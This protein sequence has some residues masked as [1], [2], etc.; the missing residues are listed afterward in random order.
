[1]AARRPH[2]QVTQGH[3]V[4]LI[5]A[6][7]LKIRTLKYRQVTIFCRRRLRRVT[8]DRLR[9]GVEKLKFPVWIDLFT[10]RSSARCTGDGYCP[11]SSATG[12]SAGL[13]AGFG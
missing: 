5:V 9:R 10:Q 8:F 11:E 13:G 2:S 6:Q 1:M 4:K 3:E 12:L 7:K